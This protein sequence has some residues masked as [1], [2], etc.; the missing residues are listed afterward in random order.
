MGL[1]IVL[2]NNA[3]NMKFFGDIVRKGYQIHFTN[4]SLTCNSCQ[5]DRKEESD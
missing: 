1:G 2:L 3:T 5:G 4:K